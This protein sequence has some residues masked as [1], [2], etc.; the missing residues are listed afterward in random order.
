VDPSDFDFDA[1]RRIWSNMMNGSRVLPYIALAMLSLQPAMAA[2][3]SP[4]YR[5]TKTVP[6]GAPDKWDYVVFDPASH[7]VF[8]AHG[9]RVSV[10]DGKDGR[11]LGAVIGFSG[12]TH[13]IGV[14]TASGRG[15]TDDG[16]AGLVGS[17]DLTTLQPGKRIKAEDDADGIVVDPASGHI[18]VVDG[19]S[20]KLT[21]ID[22]R[23]NAAIT[24]ID[25]GGGLEYAVADGKGKLY[26]NGAEKREIVRINTASNKI[27]ARWPVPDCERPHGLAA[28]FANR[29]LFSS[30]VNGVLVVVDA[31]DGRLI[32]KLPI[33]KG[34]DAAAFDPKRKLIF[35]SNGRDGTLSIIREESTES[36]VLAAT[37]KTKITAR[38]MDIDPQTGRLYLAAAD[39][40]PAARSG[41]PKPLPGTLKLLLLD[42]A[43]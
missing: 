2:E 32:A 15:Y 24:T 19:D 41:K 28:D 16:K 23:A 34:T 17:F 30:C 13:G 43:F 33:G 25:I 29:R 5:V 26:V 27:D 8:V 39:A 42:P 21:V 10:V 12:G 3:P 20:G 36:F 9:D 7:R 31:D 6:L 40:D 38:T 22:P 35:S 14:S 11:V 18:F 4:A 37:I 1:G